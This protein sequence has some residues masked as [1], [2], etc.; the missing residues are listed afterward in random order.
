MRRA[1]APL[2]AALLPLAAPAAP[3]APL[4]LTLAS[5]FSDDST[6]LARAAP[7]LTVELALPREARLALGAGASVLGQ[8]G[9]RATHTLAGVALALPL[10]PLRLEAA[11]ALHQGSGGPLHDASGALDLTLA[12]GWGIAL[13]ARHRPL[14]EGAA[15]LAT[16]EEAF[17]AAGAGGALLLPEAQWLP[18]DEARLSVRA[19]P[20]RATFVYGDGRASAIGDGNR[21]WSAA[22]GVGVDL[23]AAAA[24]GLPV[25]A[26][27]RWDAWF[28]GF[29][30]SR[31]AYFSPSFQDVQS[32]GLDLRVQLGPLAATAT[33]GRTLAL[34]SAG[35]AGWF[36][37][38]ALQVQAGGVELSLRGQVREDPWYTSRRLWLQVR[39]GL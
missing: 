25:Q 23:V 7:R 14:I 34:W 13:G 20:A 33:G 8:A 10:G 9:A 31:A 37:G 16:G 19:A 28:T 27:V 21:A 36:G 30:E 17:H 22:A 29:R 5:V 32:P 39:L 3:E 26:W 1:L 11:Y 38:G 6:G 12:E 24:P 35:Q 18:V 4:Q 15:A 2:L